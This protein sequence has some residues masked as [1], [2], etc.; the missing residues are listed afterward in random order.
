VAAQF[1]NEPGIGLAALLEKHFGVKLDKK[2]QRADWSARPLSNEMLAYAA[3][4]THHLPA[5]DAC[6]STWRPG[7]LA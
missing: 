6:G 4:D 3:T 5:C 2:F 1:L 7:R